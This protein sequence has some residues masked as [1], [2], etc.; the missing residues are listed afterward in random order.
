[1]PRIFRVMKKADGER[2]LVGDSSTCL[3]VRVP[4]DIEPVA[5]GSVHPGTGGMS[6]NPS[7]ADCPPHLVPKRLRHLMPEAR[8][9]ERNFVWRMGEGP[10]V[11]GPVADGLD[12]RPDRPGHG[13]VDPASP[14]SLDSYLAA[15]VVTRDRWDVDETGS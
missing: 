12:L 3:G 7:L 11:R 4:T 6:V 13:L 1:M 14:M 10:Y 2:P 8:G 15:I 9:S 5:D